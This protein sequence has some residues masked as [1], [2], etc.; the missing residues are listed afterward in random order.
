MLA[1]VVAS[2]AAEAIA[3]DFAV[4]TSASVAKLA[5]RVVVIVTPAEPSKFAVPETSPDKAIALGVASADAVDALPQASV[6]V[7]VLVTE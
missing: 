6:A 1:F 3:S 2:V 4:A 7:H 5:L